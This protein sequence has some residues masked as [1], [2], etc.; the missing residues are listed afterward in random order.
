[1]RPVGPLPPAGSSSKD[2][3]PPVA[4]T[5]KEKQQE[6]VLR[7]AIKNIHAFDKQK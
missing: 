3:R 5:P 7:D 6:E 4:F 1:M 2:V